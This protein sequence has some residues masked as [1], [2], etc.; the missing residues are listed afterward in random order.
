MEHPKLNHSETAVGHELRDVRPRPVLIFAVSLLAA[1]VAVQWLAWKSLLFLQR[2]EDSQ[3]Q[4]NF[5]A[6][7]L[8][9]VMP[10]IPPDPRLEPEP[11]HDVLPLAD[12]T[13]VKTREQALI[14]PN[15]WG[16]AD[17]SHHFARI[18]VQQA[19][20]LAVEHGLPDILPATQPSAPPF[21]PPAS[22]FH[23]PGGVP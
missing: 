19:I 21:M 11:S 18:P 3:N 10:T 7:P 2:Y 17:S 4:I 12:L 16:W 9:A 22:A 15:A 23:G 8:S 20:D 13:E 14:G 6:H 5:P 1:L